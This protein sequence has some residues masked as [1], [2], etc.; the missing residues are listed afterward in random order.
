MLVKGSVYTGLDDGAEHLITMDDGSEYII[1]L[2]G[3]PGTLIPAVVPSS[4]LLDSALG[5]GSFSCDGSTDRLS[6][7]L[8]KVTRA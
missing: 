6:S 1:D 3:A 4:L 2:R 5:A 7:G 8:H